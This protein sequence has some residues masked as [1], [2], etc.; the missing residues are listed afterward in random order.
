[1]KTQLFAA[2]LLVVASSFQF[3][4]AASDGTINFTGNISGA[5]CQIAVNAG[6]ATSPGTANV[7]SVTLPNITTSGMNVVGTTKG[8]TALNIKLSAC[9]PGSGTTP[10]TASVYFQSGTGVATDGTGN[11]V[12]TNTAT[13]A[14]TGIALQLF[15]SAGVKIVPGTNV[16]GQAAQ[17][18]FPSASGTVTLPFVV[19]YVSTSTVPTAGAYSG[20]V[21]Y[22]MSYN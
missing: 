12:N 17:P 2:S 5:T 8:D 22:S 14:A 9:S 3:A 21:T 13:G 16:Q 4:N 1:M 18:A 7:S 15:D 20:S 10:A 11:L 6:S 19:K